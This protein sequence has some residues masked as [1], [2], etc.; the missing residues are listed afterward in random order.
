MTVETN[1][2]IDLHEF[3]CGVTETDWIKRILT[4]SRNTLF[5]DVIVDCVATDNKRI[6]IE[7]ATL[8]HGALLNSRITNS[9][10][11]HGS[12]SKEH[13]EH[14]FNNKEVVIITNVVLCNLP[15][16]KEKFSTFYYTIPQRNLN[17]TTKKI[18][19]LKDDALIRMF[20]DKTMLKH[21]QSL[22]NFFGENNA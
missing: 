15:K 11:I 13:R 5:N 2:V 8:E 7:V 1:R 10:F 16:V 4:V 17:A 12:T 3:D 21:I 22:L 6:L 20:V 9:C 14:W 19:L 18:T